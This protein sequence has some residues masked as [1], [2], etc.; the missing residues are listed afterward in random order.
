MTSKKIFYAILL[1]SSLP[2]M[3]MEKASFER[4][5]L[6]AKITDIAQKIIKN[7]KP[8]ETKKLFLKLRAINKFFSS[9]EFSNSFKKTVIPKI[10][11]EKQNIE[12]E[13]YTLKKAKKLI[14]QFNSAAGLACEEPNQ[15]LNSKY[16]Q[17]LTL[18]SRAQQK[19]NTI[20]NLLDFFYRVDFAEMI[21]NEAPS[22]NSKK[23]LIY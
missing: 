13:L 14:P 20:N 15:E 6:P 3:S 22:T 11:K 9:Q 5:L 1:S 16:M 21:K 18:I 19:L 10:N 17:Q 4:E 23:Y 12:E 2:I 7:A 8:E